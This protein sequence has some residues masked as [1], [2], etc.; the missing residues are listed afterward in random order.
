M[1]FMVIFFGSVWGVLKCCIL[2]YRHW[3]KAFSLEEHEKKLRNKSNAQAS[4]KRK[5]LHELFRPP[6]DILHHG[7]FQSV[8][9]H[10]KLYGTWVCW[11]IFQSILRKIVMIC[12]VNLLNGVDYCVIS[13]TKTLMNCFRWWYF[14][15]TGKG[16]R[17]L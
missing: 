1:N 12:A 4:P 3:K 8:Y 16:G 11:A 5:R 13:I 10:F 9:L 6:I 14:Y 2:H 17:G 7:D 15:R